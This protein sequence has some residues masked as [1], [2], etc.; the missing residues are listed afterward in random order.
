MG[1][2]QKLPTLIDDMGGFYS[3]ASE[4]FE[5]GKVRGRQDFYDSVLDG[6]KRISVEQE[7]GPVNGPEAI[8]ATRGFHVA[9]ACAGLLVRT[10]EAFDSRR[11][12]V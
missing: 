1:D 3:H 4:A 7:S 5:A 11:K 9:Q 2:P 12:T 10:K 8:V 6:L